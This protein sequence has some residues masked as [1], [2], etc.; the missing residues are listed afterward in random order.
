MRYLPRK[1]HAWREPNPQT[2]PAILPPPPAAIGDFRVF[3][4]KN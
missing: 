3:A 2:I 4:R 1:S